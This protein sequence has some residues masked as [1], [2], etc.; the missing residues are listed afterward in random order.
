MVLNQGKHHFMCFGRNAEDETF[1][2]KN[3]IMKNSEEQK[4][5]GINIDN[6]LDFKSYVKN[7]CKKASQKNLGLSKTIK[8]LLTRKRALIFKSVIRSQFSVQ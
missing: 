3:K 8:V 5:L 7:L 4:I 2:F 1:A 6:K